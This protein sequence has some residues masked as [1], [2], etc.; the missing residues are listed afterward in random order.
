MTNVSTSKSYLNGNRYSRLSGVYITALR[1]GRAIEEWSSIP[2]L[3]EMYGAKLIGFSTS[4]TSGPNDPYF[5]SAFDYWDT[6][7]TPGRYPPATSENAI[8]YPIYEKMKFSLDSD[9]NESYSSPISSLLS[10]SMWLQDE[11]VVLEIDAKIEDRTVS[12]NEEI[13]IVFKDGRTE[14]LLKNGPSS[15]SVVTFSALAI[16]TTMEISGSP[17]S[18]SH[19]L[20]A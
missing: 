4:P 6:P 17:A 12:S 3:Q 7:E 11:L 13:S 14:T 18:D 15:I 8:Y 1:N 16:G 2:Y 5:V 9:P 20:T 19:L 10:D